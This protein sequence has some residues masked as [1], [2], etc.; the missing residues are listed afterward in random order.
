MKEVWGTDSDNCEN[1]G[2][3]EFM[4]SVPESVCLILFQV[5]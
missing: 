5:S 2:A 3:L 1:S 4:D